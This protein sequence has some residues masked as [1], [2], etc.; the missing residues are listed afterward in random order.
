MRRARKTIKTRSKDRGR[1]SLFF[2]RFYF[3]LLL[4][5]DVTYI[6]YMYTRTVFSLYR[7]S[8]SRRSFSRQGICILYSR[9]ILDRGDGHC[10]SR[11]APALAVHRRHRVN[12]L[13]RSDGV[14]RVIYARPLDVGPSPLNSKGR[15]FRRTMFVHTTDVNDDID[16]ESLWSHTFVWANR[17][18]RLVGS[19]TN[20]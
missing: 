7:Y 1:S 17:V 9:R 2:G 6:Q 8:G 4:V 19:Y 15:H 5:K 18:W 16:A 13:R 3:F 20:K 11:V 10:V 14:C 12:T